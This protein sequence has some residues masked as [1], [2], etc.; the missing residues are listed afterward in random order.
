[1][2]IHGLNK[3]T[4]L[5]YPEHVA[6]TVFTGHCNFACPF[7]HNGDLVLCPGSQPLIDESEF[8]AFL[9]KRAA[10]L[11]GVCITGGEPSIQKDLPEFIAKIRSH[12]LNV[13][14]DTNGS[15]PEILENLLNKNLLDMVAMDIKSSKAGYPEAIGIP[16]YDI[17]NVCKS[18]DILK[19]SGIPYEFR[20]TVVRELHNRE[21]FS[22]IAEW[23]KGCQAY[24]LQQFIPGERMI[25]D[26]LPEERRTYRYPNGLSAYSP[27]EM[28]QICSYLN[29]LGI[30]AKLRGI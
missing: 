14:L 3:T 27:E 20:T 17:T 10:V 2:E 11:E 9:N 4:L 25:V 6:C 18:V 1:M 16:G 30:P 23:L 29:E 21:V 24:F 7:C 12:G 5:D 13:K 26:M 15:N 8:E 28:R 22:D 19:S